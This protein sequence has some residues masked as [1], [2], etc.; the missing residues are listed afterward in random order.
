VLRTLHRDRLL[1]PR[2]TTSL[3]GFPARLDLPNR[4][5]TAAISLDDLLAAPRPLQQGLQG[6]AANRSN[7]LGHLEGLR[8]SPHSLRDVRSL[9]IGPQHE[10]V[11]SLSTATQKL[12]RLLPIAG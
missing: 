7:A 8:P 9:K 1:L 6:R 10:I 4:P 12:S 11:R 2:P 3:S 5:R